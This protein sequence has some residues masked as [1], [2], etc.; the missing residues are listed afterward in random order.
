MAQRSPQHIDGLPFNARPRRH[1]MPISKT[2]F[3]GAAIASLILPLLA[4]SPAAAKTCKD[5]LTVTSRSTIKVDEAGRTKRATA[6]AEKKW[7]KEARAK[8]GVQY[9][10][11]SRADAKNVEC[12]QTPKSTSCTMTATPCSLI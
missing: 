7:S 11:P 9:Y 6:N 5:P 4:V 12:R 3:A 8:Y 1:A 2:F 10:F